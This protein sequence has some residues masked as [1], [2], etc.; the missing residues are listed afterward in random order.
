MCDI[1]LPPKPTHTRERSL[2]KPPSPR[3]LRHPM[4]TP[5]DGSPA[6]RN[7][8]PDSGT[9]EAPPLP[10]RSHSKYTIFNCH[11]FRFAFSKLPPFNDGNI[12]APDKRQ[13]SFSLDQ[14]QAPDVPKRTQKKSTPS[15]V[16]S[17]EYVA[18]E[19]TDT[20]ETTTSN[21]V[22]PADENHDLRD[23]GIS[24]T[25]NANLNNFNH[26][27]YEDFDLRAHQQEMNINV[28]PQGESPKI[29]NPPPIPPK[30]SLGFSGSLQTSFEFAGRLGDGGALRDASESYSVPRLMQTENGQVE[31]SNG[32]GENGC[33]GNHF[34]GFC[35]WYVFLLFYFAK[36]RFLLANMH[37]NQVATWRQFNVTYWSSFSLIY[38]SDVKFTS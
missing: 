38:R 16:C 7:S 2:T 22:T 33:W 34:G 19:Q 11:C 27:N 1:P 31:T 21:L 13:S 12:S 18:L 6:M 29:E 36:R 14:Q 35:F 15:S 3:L 10:P 5:T 25:E 24:M 30:S 32:A 26:T 8:W 37:M 4:A 9:E 28:S 17:I 20:P 23:S